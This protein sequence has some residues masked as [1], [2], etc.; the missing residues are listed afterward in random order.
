MK[1]VFVTLCLIFFNTIGFTQTVDEVVAPNYIR[2]IQFYG[3]SQENNG[4]P[5]LRLGEK[6]TLSFDDIIGDEADYYYT[7]EHFNYNWEPTQLAKAEY[8]SGL[9]QIRI[10]NYQNSYNTL[11]PFSHYE[12]NIPN[13]DTEGLKVSGNYML[14]IFNESNELVFSR[15]F[16]V[17]EPIAKVAVT[18]K[19]SRDLNFV[20]N[21]QVVNFSINSPDVLLKNPNETVKVMIIQNQDLK[22]AIKDIKPQYT[23]ANELIYRY[24]EET[25]F[26]AGNE[27]LQFDSKD[28]RASTASINYI[29]VKELYHHFLFLDRSRDTEPYTYHPDI[30]GG[31]VIRSLQA[32]DPDIEAE[33][34]WVHFK[35]KN[36]EPLE[37]G[38]LH[39]FGNFNNFNLND[40]TRLEYNED[41]GFYETARLFKQGYYDYKYVLLNPDGSLNE[42]FISG[43]FDK[44]ENQYQVLAYYRKLG[45]R[46]DRLIGV[47]TAN[48]R[49]ITN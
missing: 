18:I 15:K 30:N 3:D 33:Y 11:Q 1:N 22:G 7:I 2:S 32:Q 26:W 41:S 45:A 20:E 44:T 39:L 19:R 24:D 31:F 4:N 5:I 27:Y 49:N 6:I 43:N 23:L 47:G 10:M 34:V 25:S 38:Q 28:L 16:M 21:K 36:F 40:E 13:Q 37:G 12:L 48:S 14:K 29:E 8:L 35:L 42:G 9:D 46:Y 17:F